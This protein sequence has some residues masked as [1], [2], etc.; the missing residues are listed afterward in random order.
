MRVSDSD[1]DVKR[2]KRFV[3]KVFVFAVLG[4]AMI[5]IGAEASHAD[6]SSDLQVPSIPQNVAAVAISSSQ[7]KI[8][9]NAS[10]DNVGVT[11][12]NIYQDGD[13]IASIHALSY[14]VTG[15]VAPTRHA[16]TVSAYDA[17]HNVSVQSVAAIG[18]IPS[19]DTQA[20]S[21]PQNVTAVPI[22]SSQIKVSWSASTDNVAVAGYRVYQ[23]DNL[24]IA[25]NN[26]NT[27]FTVT[28]LVAPT[29]HSYEVSAVDTAG[30]ISAESAS[31]AAS[32]SAS[33]SSGNGSTYD[34]AILADHPVAFWDVNPKSTTESDLTGNGN[35]GT[36]KNGLPLAVTLPNGDRSADFNGSSEYLTV[37]SNTSFSIPK[38]GNL[39]W[40][41]WIRPDV[42]QFPKSSSDGYADFMGKCATYSP[43]CEWEGRMYDSTTSQGRSN[44]ISAYV[45][46]TSAGLG[47]AA[48]WQPTSG[49]VQAG[50]W[51]HVVGEY[52]TQTQPSTCS[53]SGTYPGSINIWVNGVKWDQAEH[54]PTGCMSQYSVR[55]QSG[56]S[57][58]NIGTMALDTWF[59][60]AVGKVAIYNYLLSPT[61]I[62]NH[63]HAMTGNEP[64]GSC[65]VTCSY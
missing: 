6:T 22:S 36:Y 61:Q 7:I 17:A 23:N 30:N 43:T 33:G 9:W 15:L 29:T 53:N 52:T 59:K 21:V 56:S 5:A 4:L 12:Y 10:S 55:P 65:G 48:D 60:G 28:G 37:P 32:I 14:T 3:I 19:T 38:T 20:P 8:S 41:A 54:N 27:S 11:G 1:S 47:S 49:V 63:Y 24:I 35:T 44:R 62:D 34:Q 26:L 31:A 58:L 18:S 39:T 40:E 25:T 46:N 42:L 13:W 57:S 2:R 45:F 16:Y 50:Q 64:T 51:I